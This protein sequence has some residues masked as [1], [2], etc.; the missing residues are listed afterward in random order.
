MV[1]VTM[2]A[3]II[4]C[5]N[6]T[7]AIPEAQREL[8]K[9]S[10]DL[11]TSPEGWDP[12]ALN[13][14]Q[15][16]AMRFSTPLIHGEVSRLLIDLQEDGDKR[17]GKISSTLPE[18]SRNKLVE[19][20]QD[21]FRHAIEARLEEDFKR[22]DM[23]LHLDIHTAPIEDGKIIF[24]HIASSFAQNVSDA[25]IRLL[26]S[27]EV[28]SSSVPLMEKTPFIRWLLE[29]FPSGKYGIIRITVSQSFF[30]RSVPMRWET[31]KKSLIQALADATK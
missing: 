11:V 5:A 18:A 3:I 23:A 27:N 22:H 30:M 8:F 31:I 12:G 6:A 9:G 14:A 17:W 2:A 24:E 13:L 1:R 28:D 15:G 19:R 10:E 20:Q 16:L 29:T 25:A 7:C 26:P 4:T 21:K